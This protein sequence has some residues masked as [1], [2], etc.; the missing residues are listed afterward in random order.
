MCIL[1]HYNGHFQMKDKRNIRKGFQRIVNKKTGS[2]IDLGA[3]G[4]VYGE[5]LP[6]TTEMI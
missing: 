3:L 6:K 4:I 1:M 5:L 2:A